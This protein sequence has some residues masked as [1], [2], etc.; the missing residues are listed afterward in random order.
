MNTFK[1]CIT[2]WEKLVDQY[3]K[4][5]KEIQKQIATILKKDWTP[6][7]PKAITEAQMKQILDRSG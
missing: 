5:A 1:K 2:K 7:N 3:D 6:E 4:D